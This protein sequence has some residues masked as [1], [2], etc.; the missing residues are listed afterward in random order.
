MDDLISR[1]AAIDCISYDE[2]Y[3]FECLKALPS[4]QPEII[5]YCKDCRKHNVRVGFDEKKADSCPLVS[6]RGKAWGHEFD[7]QYC[8]YA[9]RREE[10]R[11]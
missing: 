6:W 8:P 7:Y 1:Q 4:A 11:D 3:T 5:I 10:Q 2:E 9:E